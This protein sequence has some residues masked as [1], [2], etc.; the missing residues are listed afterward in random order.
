MSTVF[1]RSGGSI[2]KIDPPTDPHGAERFAA[3]LAKRDIELVP[4]E[5][6]TETTSRHGGVIYVLAAPVP[7]SDDQADTADGDAKP[8]A[9]KDLVARALELGIAAK[10]SWSTG[11]LTA[12][13]AAAEEDADAG[14]V[15]A[16]DDQADTA[17]GD[18]PGE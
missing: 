5:L 18:A 9:K 12:E 15:P 1:I 17:D 10:Q 7:A 4:D 8:P 11:R 3:A 2:H 14:A 13:I 16:S 6:V